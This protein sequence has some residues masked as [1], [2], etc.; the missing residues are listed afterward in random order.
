[1]ADDTKTIGA[2]LQRDLSRPIE[3]IV[4][5]D[6]A[7]DETVYE[8]L[9]EYVATASIQKQYRKVLK[10]IADAPSEPSK[11]IGIW[12]SGFFGSGK[13]SFAKNLGYAL[14]NPQVKG[15]PAADLFKEAV[16]DVD[17]SNY[18]DSINAR[19][20][21]DVVMFDVTKA[22]EVRRSDEKIAEVVY[23]SLLKELGYAPDYDIAELEIELEAQGD[24]DEFV[25]LSPGI[26]G[27]E[28]TKARKGAQKLNYAS[29]ILHRMKPGVF[30][31]PD[32]WAKAQVS[33]TTALTVDRVV[34]RVFELF[35]RRRPGHAVVFI[36]D[37]VGQYVARSADKIEDLR[38]LVEALGR[39]SVER[40][41]AKKAPAPVWFVVTSQERLDEV[42]AAIDSKR[43]DLAKL[44]DRF[45]YEVDMSPEDINQVATQRVLAKT[46]AAD[47]ILRDLYRKHEGQL[48]DALRLERSAI[49][50]SVS[51]D[52]FVG[53]YPYPPHVIDVCIDIVS[54][55]RLQPGAPRH[56]GGS[57]RT[58]IKQA[59]EMLASD[60][61]ALAKAPVGTLVTMD[62][63]YDLVEGNL[64]TEKR[65]DIAKIAD[66]YGAGG[67]A[68]RVAKTIALLEFVRRVPRTAANVAAFL[69]DAVG[70]PKPLAD[71]EVALAE[72]QEGQFVRESE[73]GWK[74]QTDQEK[75]WDSERRAYDPRPRDRNEILRAAVEDL[76]RRPTL[77]K[78]RMGQKIF[79]VAVALDGVPVGK[80]G[81]IP[82]HLVTADE[83]A[84]LQAKADSVR[85]DSR[86]PANEHAL[87]WA[88]ALTPDV[89][90]LVAEVYASRQMVV[91]Y[92]QL[93]AQNKISAEE[94]ALLQSEK[95]NGAGLQRRLQDKLEGTLR[96][97]HP[98]FR[99]VV[100]DA[101][102]FGPTLDP[103]IK[104]FFDEAV[105][106][107]YAKLE[108]GVR[109]MKGDEPEK[110]LSAA[111]LNG[112]PPVFYDGPD[113]LDL[114]VK[115]QG[116]YVMNPHAEIAQEVL[117]YLVR[118]HEYGNKVT[119]KHIESV[120]EGVGYGWDREVY[121]TV[122]ASL[123]RAGAIEVGYQGRRFRNHSDPQAKV[124][125]AKTP[126]FR[127]A[128]FAPRD[129]ID[130]KTLI[131]A[132]QRFEELTG[133]EI[134]VEESAI[135]EGFKRLAEAEIRTLLPVSA[136][137]A[138][139]QIPVGDVLADYRAILEEALTAQSDDCVRML[140]GEGRTIAEA[141]ERV[142]KVHAL[143][144]HGGV[145]TVEA[146]RRAV[147]EMAPQL[148][149]SPEVRE[150]AS[151]LSELLES[152]AFLD[153]VPRVKELADSV[154]AA[155]VQ[156]YEDLH[157]RRAAAYTEAIETV[158]GRSDW[159]ELS[160]EL[161]PD[162]LDAILAPLRGRACA[163]LDLD[164]GTR[165]RTCR[166]TI[167]QM[168]S[169]LAALDSLHSAAVA[170][171]QELLAPEEEDAKVEHVRVRQF[172]GDTLDSEKAV[173][174][175]VE[176]LRAH[177]LKLVSTGARIVIN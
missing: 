153:Q 128:S 52:D 131:T 108:M 24:L 142:A 14:R 158:Q 28:W 147:R 144:Q 119:G 143:V 11:A 102:A 48:K 129:S 160:A 127:S 9:A 176:R 174:Q 61:T 78:Y 163:N 132:V 97:G 105:P 134:D 122:L 18:V 100:Y 166:A 62:K 107:L 68:H 44:Q 170:R 92:D 29:A 85:D 30:S 7:D 64:R 146:A 25:A 171:V 154:R 121:Y 175:S 137:V 10:A 57:N 37:E 95:T 82:L 115:D 159:L 69:V 157:G 88:F 148:A 135:A 32:S 33:S 173:E 74:L 2:L 111:N 34:A 42:V 133:E 72:L 116:K 21:T 114:V 58:I 80:D 125:F 99:G 41:K 150:A 120:F 55:I 130:L 145:A 79:A 36:V 43:V 8:E 46:V 155:Y 161:P 56:L 1:M 124:P 4:Q 126:T 53:F 112:L 13:S 168:E 63:V 71:V 94:A 65:S 6:E 76:F 101:S 73:D 5:V 70:D 31:S 110:I 118:Q 93:R 140:A 117:R 19:L 106:K 35:A 167:Q 87:F 136:E 59:Y 38:A 51:E 164:G 77:Q 66:A 151:E 86:S 23:R 49:D 47:P 113:G 123:L 149:A 141:R 103:A 156:T 139:H 26:N 91:A 162:A 60:Q 98:V 54:G 177:L 104:G 138:A 17:V 75:T 172:F 40:V 45:K 50:S 165:C 96:A 89:D 20:Y 3:E 90:K 169:D 152:D 12:V 81:Q 27:L 84:A 67:V 83:P 109:T 15:R 22:S 16:E 39:E